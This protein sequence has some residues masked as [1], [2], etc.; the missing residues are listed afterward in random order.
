MT[1][2]NYIIYFVIFTAK[3]NIVPQIKIMLQLF[4]IIKSRKFVE[5]NVVVLHKKQMFEMYNC[6]FQKTLSFMLQNQ[7]LLHFLIT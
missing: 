7:H 1:K 4:S 2:K 6:T 3:V 5:Q